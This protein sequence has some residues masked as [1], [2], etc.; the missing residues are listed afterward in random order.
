MISHRLKILYITSIFVF[1]SCQAPVI[2]NI[3]SDSSNSIITANHSY[4]RSGFQKFNL[5]DSLRIT[6]TKSLN[7]L[8]YFSFLQY[9]GELIYTTHNGKL[10]FTQLND[11]YNTRNTQIA[12]GIGAAPTIH[13]KTLFIPVNKGKYGLVAYDITSAKYQW[14]LSGK[15]SQSSPIV[16][17]NLV[18]HTST[19]GSVGAYDIDYA[20]RKWEI[21]IDD[22]ILNN[23]A[24]A[25]N[26]LVVLTQN[27]T[28]RSYN[29]NSG[30]L[31]WSLQ[32]D[33][34]FYASPVVNSSFVFVAGYKGT[35]TKIDLLKGD[36]LNSYHTQV[37]IYQ[38]P[39]LDDSFLYVPKANGHLTALDIKNL[40]EQ[41]TLELEGPFTTSPLVSNSEVIIGTA[42]RKMYRVNKINGT[43][44]Q[45]IELEGR[46]RSQPVYHEN[47]IYISYEPDYLAILSSGRNIEE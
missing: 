25:A 15:F 5:G 29:P 3:Y 47:K 6:Q 37:A 43:V 34:A 10:Y 16:N 18:I 8:P 9:S 26:N 32:I 44:I 7:G 30:S 46:P 19:D 20:D 28:I 39:A 41:W 14:E 23:L 17:N 21:N 31:N 13:N 40:N 12:V 2:K 22:R 35:I 45:V 4:T 36:I 11:F 33:D 24:L 38:T 42:T 1:L 27:G